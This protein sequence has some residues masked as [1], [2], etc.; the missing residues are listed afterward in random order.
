L[1]DLPVINVVLGTSG[2]IDHGK[3]TLIKRLTGIDAD[4][5]K[6]EKARGM[7]IDIGY[8][9][10]VVDKRLHLGIIDV[11]GHERFVKNMVAGATGLG[12]VLLVVAADD[13]IMPQTREHLDI[14]ELLG[15][16]LGAAVL[17]KIDLV[18]AETADL[19]EEELRE[20][21]KGSFL[22]DA[23]LVRVSSLTG[24]GFDRL[25]AVIADLV[26]SAEVPSAAG[27]FYLPV[28][29]SFAAEGYGT[30]V[31]GV[32]MRGAVRLGDV[33]EV[34]PSGRA[35]RVRGIEAYGRRL[36]Q[37]FAGHRVA[38]NLADIGHREIGRGDVVG[39][40]GALRAWPQIVARMRYLASCKAPFRSQ[41]PVHFHVGTAESLARAVILDRA[42]IAPGEDGLVQFRLEAP[43]I[44]APGDRFIV[45]N[46]TPIDTIGGGVVI[47]GVEKRLKPNRS[48][49][50]EEIGHW[51]R[52]TR[53]SE[54][55][56]AEALREAGVEP[57][58][59]K[60]TAVAA[61]LLPSEAERALAALR[62]K[63]LAR[64]VGQGDRFLLEASFAGLLAKIEETLRA[65]HGEKPLAEGMDRVELRTA[66]GASKPLF[67]A[68]LAALEEAGRIQSAGTLA[69][70]PGFSVGLSETE[71]GLLAELERRFLDAGTKPPSADE[72]QAGLDPRLAPAL[73]KLLV[74]RGVLVEISKEDVVFHR[75]TLDGVREAV[76]AEIREKGELQPSPF[77]DRIATTRKYLIPLLEYF[78]KMGLT[79]RQESARVLREHGRGATGG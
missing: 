21:L 34:Q 79:V 69:R 18:D 55:A 51:E 63:G 73:Y 13:G 25:E 16:R 76:I 53:G 17:N 44:A 28:Q 12:L 22:Q 57:L 23:P 36:E 78:D 9:H 39:T 71:Q 24:Q 42:E 45:R 49:I 8:A 75:K 41:T 66:S 35:V 64:A 15:I 65:F 10:M 5:L 40:P 3:T 4:R 70:L 74:Q 27:P 54:E 30:V 50:A 33:L 77:R 37:A 32:P 7:T 43:L 59:A 60:E 31:T 11:P 2:H 61:F 72:A 46:I 1:A 58:T 38:L 67:E 52:L 47:R 26:K 14:L 62:A 48:W 20:F 6:E 29:R 56:A 19:A 68:A